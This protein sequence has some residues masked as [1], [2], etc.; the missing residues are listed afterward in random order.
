MG[1]PIDAQLL[2]L[3]AGAIA[4]LAIRVRNSGSE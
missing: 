3:I 4:L 2:I 1:N